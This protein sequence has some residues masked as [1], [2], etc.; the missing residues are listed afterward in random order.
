[1]WPQ[2]NHHR[3][4]RELMRCDSSTTH[5]SD[6]R[7]GTEVPEW[8]FIRPHCEFIPVWCAVRKLVMSTG[9]NIWSGT[10][11]Y[12]HVVLF[13]TIL[14]C[15]WGES[16]F[17]HFDFVVLNYGEARL[18]F[19]ASDTVEVLTCKTEAWPN[20]SFVFETSST[21]LYFTIYVFKMQTNEYWK[22][23]KQP[24]KLNV[25]FAALTFI[26]FP[27]VV[28]CKRKEN[29][30]KAQSNQQNKTKRVLNASFAQPRSDWVDSSF[31][32]VIALHSNVNK[33]P[34]LYVNL[35]YILQKINNTCD[36]WKYHW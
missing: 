28:I 27:L 10:S 8:L 17:L 29:F 30:N 31:S 7:L 19:T 20:D 32:V 26:F 16:H 35:M 2:Q 12:T 3:F 5:Q 33:M 34:H 14:Y 23:V 22:S 1:M 13:C 11:A 25:T 15:L 4:W 21:P 9:S 36:I 6:D 24:L 18:H